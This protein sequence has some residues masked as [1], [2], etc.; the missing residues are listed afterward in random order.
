MRLIFVGGCERSGTSLVQ[1]ILTSHSRIAGGPEFVFTGRVADLY[2]RMA[3]RYP[4]QYATRIEAFYDADQLA[5]TFRSF[6]ES[7]YC[8]LFEQKKGALYFSEKTPSNIF[9]APRLLRIFPDSLFIHV[10]RDGRGVLSSHRDVRKRFEAARPTGGHLREQG[11]VVYN[12]GTFR[13]WR[14]CSRWNRA[15]EAHFELMADADMSRRCI[16]VKYEDLLVEPERVL[17]ELFRFLSLDLEGAALAPESIS[18]AQAGIPIDGFWYTEEMYNRGFDLR[19]ID[20]WKRCL[21]PATRVLGSVLMATNLHRLSY[22]VAGGYL[23]ANSALR[24]VPL[25]PIQ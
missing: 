4:G 2:H 25:H 14:I 6:Y 7:F 23:R 24:R 22:P 13:T 3:A 19:R 20:R 15:A 12:R 1:K 8:K 10:I 11:E 9:A 5:A 17:A 18:A 16:G 21:P